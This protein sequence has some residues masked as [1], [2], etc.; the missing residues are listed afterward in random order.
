MSQ[1][2]RNERNAN[3]GIVVGITPEPTIRAMPLA[4]I[5]LQRHWEARAFVLGGGR[6]TRRRRSWSGDFLSGRA[7]TRW[8]RSCRRTSRACTPAD[9]ARLPAGL[10]DAAIREALPAFDRQIR[11]FAIADA[12]MTGVETRTSSPV[13][14][15][16]DEDVQSLNTRGLSRPAKARAMRAASFRPGRRHPR[17]RSGGVLGGR[18]ADGGADDAGGRGWG[19]T[20]RDGSNRIDS[21]QNRPG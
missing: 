17:R 11:G 2:S 7:S 1:Y 20:G 5:A 9:L 8:A 14:I 12:V 10:R 3:A 13:R 16:R 18:G 4:G 15:T 21:R 6:T 19:C